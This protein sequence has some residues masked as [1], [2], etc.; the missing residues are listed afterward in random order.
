MYFITIRRQKT[1]LL[2]RQ[3]TKLLNRYHFRRKKQKQ[4]P[5]K[6]MS[7]Q[8]TIIQ[9]LIYKIFTCM[10]RL[11]GCNGVKAVSV[12]ET[13]HVLSLL[14]NTVVSIWEISFRS[15]SLHYH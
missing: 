13:A 8:K 2:K 5:Q 4:R 11:R 1:K 15:Q 10:V 6:P 12:S 3:K 14:E 7:Q 9:I